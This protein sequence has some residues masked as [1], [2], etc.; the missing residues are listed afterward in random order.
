MPPYSNQSIQSQT[1]L[2]LP[3]A[4]SA[5]HGKQADAVES[6]SKG[7]NWEMGPNVPTMTGDAGLVTDHFLGASD[8]LASAIRDEEQ[9]VSQI[10]HE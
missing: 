6:Y 3:R 2:V 4:E 5:R 7:E 8:F 10:F 9:R 1:G